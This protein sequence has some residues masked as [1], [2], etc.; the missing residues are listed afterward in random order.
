MSNITENA[1]W[2]IGKTWLVSSTRPNAAM[3]AV[4]AKT[5]GS[6]AATKAPNASSRMITVTGTDRS[7]ARWKSLPAESSAALAK[8]ASP[9]SSI[10][11]AGLA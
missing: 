4:S 5:T 1:D 8:L 6:T 7:S 9:N 3:M 2:S 11:K 10:R